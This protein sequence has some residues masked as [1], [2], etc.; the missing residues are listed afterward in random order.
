MGPYEPG[1]AKCPHC[2]RQRHRD[3]QSPRSG[4]CFDSNRDTIRLARPSCRCGRSKFGQACCPDRSGHLERLSN[5]APTGLGQ[6]AAEG[7]A[8]DLLR[9]PSSTRSSLVR[10]T[11][12]P[13]VLRLCKASPLPWRRSTNRRCQCRL[14]LRRTRPLL[15]HQWGR[16]RQSH[17]H[18][19]RSGL[20]RACSCCVPIHRLTVLH[21]RHTARS[22]GQCPS[23]P[24]AS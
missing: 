5:I 18:C 12:G 20:R 21:H 11:L 3:F 19:C 22:Q 2:N 6:A 14:G 13:I 16:N 17:R 1:N 23:C 15:Q 7:P 4:H 10:T 24:C 9:H 8:K